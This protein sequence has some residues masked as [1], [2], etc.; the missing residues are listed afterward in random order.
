MSSMHCTYERVVIGSAIPGRPRRPDSIRG[1]SLI[2]GS[3]SSRPKNS[4]TFTSRRQL[5][6]HMHTFVCYYNGS[7]LRSASWCVIWQAGHSIRHEQVDSLYKQW[8]DFHDVPNTVSRCT[9]PYDSSQNGSFHM[10]VDGMTNGVYQNQIALLNY[11][12]ARVWVSQV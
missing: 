12:R 7:K 10:S 8:A 4:M 9:N 2:I 3:R 1:L 11:P 5:Q 6:L